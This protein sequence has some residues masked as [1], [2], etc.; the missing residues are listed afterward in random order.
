MGGAER[1]SGR[2]RQESAGDAAMATL[3]Q[4]VGERPWGVMRVWGVG[5][6]GVGVTG[7]VA[8]PR[9]RRR[10]AF[11]FSFRSRHWLCADASG[12]VPTWGATV[13]FPIGC[14]SVNHWRV[15]LLPSTRIRQIAG[16]KAVA[17]R[18]DRAGADP[19][20]HRDAGLPMTGIGDAAGGC[21]APPPP[22]I[23]ARGHRARPGLGGPGPR[24]ESGVRSRLRPTEFSSSSLARAVAAQPRRRPVRLRVCAVGRAG[25][26]PA[27]CRSRRR[28]PDR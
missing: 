6:W 16:R 9:K 23:R 4:M 19:S 15:T 27:G 1:C 5:W 21:A 11:P 12:S 2:C 26:A 28:D 18:P 24:S 17:W 10:G 25:T 20:Q 7:V 22:F 13:R 3:T 8:V 14:L